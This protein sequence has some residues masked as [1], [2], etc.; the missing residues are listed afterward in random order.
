ME[1][2]LDNLGQTNM[3]EESAREVFCALNIK[4]TNQRINIAKVIFR[5]EQHLSAEDIITVLNN[6][7]GGISRATV[8][9]TLNLFVDKGLVQRVVIGASKIY[10]D[11]KTTPHSH[12]F[13]VDTGEIL[14]FECDNVEISPLPALPEDTVQDSVDIVIRIKNSK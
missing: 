4:P 7:G 13:N 2:A 5:K 9:N 3:S 12:Y 8:Y 1:H 14:D 6:N 11:S 10:Y